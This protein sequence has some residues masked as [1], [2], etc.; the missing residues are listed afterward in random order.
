MKFQ[1]SPVNKINIVKSASEVVLKLNLDSNPSS[2]ISFELP[3]NYLH[4]KAPT[5]MYVVINIAK[6]LMGTKE[7]AKASNKTPSAFH[8]FKILKI[9][10]VR[11]AFKILRFLLLPGMRA[12]I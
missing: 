1:L 2:V 4:I 10:I 7:L 5:N 12:S 9:L 6:F 8:F 11:N 3:K